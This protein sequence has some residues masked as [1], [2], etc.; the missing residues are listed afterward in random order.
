MTRAGDNAAIFIET[1]WGACQELRARNPTM[2]IPDAGRINQ[3]LADAD[4]GY[5]LDPPILTATRVHIPINVPNAPPSLDV[6]AQALIN[7]SLDASQRALSDGN[8][9]QAVQEVLWLLETISTAFRSQEILDG[10]IQGR[11]FNKIIGELRQRGRGH[12]DQIFQWMMTLHGYLSSPTGGGVRHGVDLKEGLAL[13]IDEAR[14]Y[15]NLIRSY[16]TFLIAEHE[17]LSRREAQ[18]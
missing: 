18:I 3:I 15:C 5:Q 17:R 13:E 14:L 16:L 9:R 2:V 6:Q 10:S 1:F 11:Y 4:A 8:G 7:E 12:Q